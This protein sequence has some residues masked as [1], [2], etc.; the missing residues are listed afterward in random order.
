MRLDRNDRGATLGPLAQ[1]TAGHIF[2]VPAGVPFLP[3]L[4]AAVLRGNLPHPG[5]V[6]PDTLNLPD[7]R[8]L[9]P[10]RRATRALQQAF[11]DASRDKALLIPRIRPIAPDE[12]DALELLRDLGEGAADG[13]TVLAPAIGEIDRR[14]TLAQLVLRWSEAM[15]SSA[16]HRPLDPASTAG[17][18]TPAQAARL[19][20]ELARLM[21]TFEIENVSL[22]R[23]RDLAPDRFAAHW[24]QTLKF[25]EIV[26]TFWPQHLKERNLLSPMERRNRLILGE[27]QSLLSAPPQHPV[28][29]A[30]ATGSIPATVDLMRA[31]L[32]SPVGALV[33]PGVDTT[34]DDESWSRLP[35]HPGHPQHGLAKLLAALGISRDQIRPLP[36]C[37]VE[38][39][40]A[41][42]MRIISEAMRPAPSTHRWSK[43]AATC[44]RAAVREAF[45]HVACIEA[46]SAPEEAEVIALILRGALEVPGQTAALVSPDRT[47]ARRV[48][49]RLEAWGLHVDDSAGRPFAK[50]VPGAFLDLVVEAAS[51]QFEPARLVALLKHPLTRLGW[52][53]GRV[54]RAARA[55]ELA[56]FRTDYFGRGLAGVECALERARSLT[57]A[58][59][60]RHRAVQRLREEDWEEARKLIAALKSAYEPLC[61]LLDRPGQHPYRALVEAHV[62]TAERLARLPEESAETAGATLWQGEEGE[63]AALLMAGLLDTQAAAPR[64]SGADYPDFLRSLIGGEN[65]RPRFPAHPRLSI[66]GPLEARLMQPDVVILGSLNEGT[67]PAAADP[68]P[69]LNRSM[70]AHLGLPQAE[71][72]IGRAAHDF[73]QLLGAPKV[74]LTRAQKVNGVPTVPSRWMLRLKALLAGLGAGDALEPGEPWLGWARERDAVRERC[75]I[76]APAPRPPLALRPR[77]LSVSDVERW[78][79]NPYAIFAKKILKLE[80][81]P[82]LGQEPGAALRGSIVHEA[83]SRFA[84]QYPERLPADIKGE[85]MAIATTVLEDWTGNARVAAF[86][87]PRLE[88]FAEWFAETEPQR[89]SN[90]HLVHAEVDGAMVLTAPAGPFTLRARADRIDQGGAGAIVTDYKTASEQQIRTLAGRAGNGLAPQL[91]LEAAILLAAGFTGIAGGPLAELRYISASGGEPPGVEIA[92]KAGDPAQ[93]ARQA[94]DGLLRLVRDFDDVG[95]PYRA[96]RR[97][98]FNYRFDDYAHL[99]RAGE[100]LSDDGRED[101]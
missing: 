74:F 43:L 9:L 52:P 38:R 89:R 64:L 83:L 99:A 100:W 80:R 95:T 14:L 29:V 68:G 48:L 18:A 26:L 66:W 37:E 28:I 49:V 94:H 67:W 41:A 78:I 87:V 50:T 34:L 58:G 69:W 76:Q 42:R 71:E 39:P 75:T 17:A 10:T 77:S 59:T 44:D 82:A 5:G 23:L 6:P 92:I 98:Q 63:A 46:A 97:A 20:R 96:V 81:L 33:L 11:L 13:S 61:D 16:D 53:A 25:L 32:A 40:I 73:S 93:L 4:A 27:A 86:W 70:R 60:R 84:R 55:L 19:A 8:I 65:V 56:A 12:E 45:A 54:R 7:F 79:A 91:P 88:R 15:R 3:A 1:R 24:Q 72:E 35:D 90:T 30:G 36:G 101:A 51:R 21:D 2:T 62:R 31:V 22:E 47:L 57:A 85:L